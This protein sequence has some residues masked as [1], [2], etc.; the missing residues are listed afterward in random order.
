MINSVIYNMLL[1]SD[2]LMCCLRETEEDWPSLLVSWTDF[3]ILNTHRLLP[4]LA[5]CNSSTVIIPG[6]VWFVNNSRDEHF[7]LVFSLGILAD[8]MVPLPKSDLGSMH[9]DPLLGWLAEMIRVGEVPIP[10]CGS[11]RTSRQGTFQ[12]RSWSFYKPLT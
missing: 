5:I 8:P 3:L 2:T 1:L 6:L 9:W 7:T 12:L 10:D 4:H 11:L